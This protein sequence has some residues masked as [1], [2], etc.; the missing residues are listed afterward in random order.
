MNTVKD[1]YN[2]NFGDR[3]FIWLFSRKMAE[4]LGQ[5]TNISG[6]GGFV[7][8][9]KKIMSGRNAQEQQIIV[10]EVLQSLV[11]APILW[12]VQIGRAHV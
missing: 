12:A 7:D 9:S 6:Y 1:E 8:L 4:A 11:P 3:L 5:D 2:D 10:A